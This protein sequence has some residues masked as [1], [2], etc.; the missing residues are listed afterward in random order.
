M[1]IA[2][3][4]K[5]W[6]R[7]ATEPIASYIVEMAA[8]NV[9]VITLQEVCSGQHS[10]IRKRLGSKW[11]DMFKNFGR[12]HACGDAKFGLSIFTKGEYTDPWWKYLKCSPL[13]DLDK[14][15][16]ETKND[17][18]WGLLKVRFKGV[19]VYCVHTRFAHREKQIPELAE[20]LITLAAGKA[21]V[22][23]DF[24]ATPDDPLMASFYDKWFECDAYKQPTLRTKGTKVDYL[25]TTWKPFQRFGGPIDLP[26]LSNHRLTWAL[27]RWT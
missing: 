1:N 4:D 12:V 2:G 17:G 9:D 20:L 10:A 21:I 23:G 25:W 18:A 14:T 19:D 15:D 27:I 26:A 8:E 16:K 6:A 13:G 7:G 24:N 3:A 22:A 5:G 11:S